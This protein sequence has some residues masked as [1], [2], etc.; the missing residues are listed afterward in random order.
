MTDT[1]EFLINNFPWCRM[2]GKSL[3]HQDYLCSQGCCVYPWNYDD[4]I[5]RQK[6]QNTGDLKQW[7][8]SEI[9]DDLDKCMNSCCDC[10]YGWSDIV[11]NACYVKHL[12]S[13][14]Y[15]GKKYSDKIELLTNLIDKI[16]IEMYNK[17]CEYRKNTFLSGILKTRTDILY[18]HDNRPYI[19]LLRKQKKFDIIERLPQKKNIFYEG[20]DYYT[21]K[22]LDEQ[23]TNSIETL[24]TEKTKLGRFA[25]SSFAFS[26]KKCKLTTD[27]LQ[28]LHKLNMLELQLRPLY[29]R[30]KLIF[31]TGVE[32]VDW[33]WCL[34]KSPLLSR[35]IIVDVYGYYDDKIDSKFTDEE[36][37]IVKKFYCGETYR[38]CDENFI[39]HRK[40]EKQNS[41][42]YP[43]ITLDKFMKNII[44]FE[45]DNTKYF[46]YSN[47]QYPK[48]YDNPDFESVTGYSLCAESYKY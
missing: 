34:Y 29:A 43:I 20:N 36:N 46:P 31:N 11:Q 18:E 1:L 16:G 21:K 48:L 26:S 14:L 8:S 3:P 42:Y 15:L 47:K 41:D 37:Y 2:C 27:K 45:I 4:A 24:L 32:G 39:I 23:L 10:Q 13:I 9:C 7:P 38:N 12:M 44:M 35:T 40:P 28:K 6:I 22:C 19:N 30:Q 25:F 17:L 33:I 5:I